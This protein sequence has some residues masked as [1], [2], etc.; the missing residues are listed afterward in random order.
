MWIVE[1]LPSWV[2]T[3]LALTGIGGL[4]AI[5][6]FKFI[7]IISNYTVP[8]KV[9]SVILLAIGL[10]MMGSAA[11]EAKWELRVKE[12]EAKLAQAEA[13]SQKENVKIVE[14]IVTKTQVVRE[15]G[16]E[17]IRYVDREIVKY[18]EKF[19]P[20]GVCEIPPEFIKAHNDAAE[21]QK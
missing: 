5:Q 13:T 9:V 1:W 8:I 10:Y 14:K 15:K 21:V 3:L 7:P 2:F 20:G 6:F 17:I 16:E 11:N 12:L 19:A 18:D 4:V